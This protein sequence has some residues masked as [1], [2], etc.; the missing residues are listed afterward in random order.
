MPRSSAPSSPRSSAPSSPR[1]S[2]PSAPSGGGGGSFR[3]GRR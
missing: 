2:M 3:G 1:M